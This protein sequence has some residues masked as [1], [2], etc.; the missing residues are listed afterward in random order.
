M[1]GAAAAPPRAVPLALLAVAATLG[2][3]WMAVARL[4]PGYAEALAQ[5]GEAPT[6]RARRGRPSPAAE[7]APG[8]LVRWWLRDP[9]ER[10]A[11]QLTAVYLR[12][13]RETKTRLYPSLGFFLLLPVAQLFSRATYS[14]TAGAFVSVLILGML[15]SVILEALRTS[16]HHAASEIFAAVPLGSAAPLFHG[17]RKAAIYY[18]I[19]PGTVIALL[20]IAATD[21]AKLPVAVPSLLALPFLSLLPAAGRDYVPLSEPPTTGRQSTANVVVGMLITLVGAVVL[22][23]AWAAQRVG[24]LPYLIALQVVVMLAAC[25]LLGA[26]IRRRPLR[27]EA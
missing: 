1:L 18:V 6:R 4:A 12:R 5:L 27:R 9:A 8:R 24:L 7:R 13:D 21:A 14:L 10:A 17:A 26:H 11:F 3:G 2:L 20:W 16:S 25:R 23:V 19:L 15:P 22:A